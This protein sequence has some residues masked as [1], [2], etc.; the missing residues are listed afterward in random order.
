MTP[1]PA[2]PPLRVAKPV[3]LYS[4]LA[5]E[6]P[7]EELEDEELL[8]EELLE[9]EL[10]D[11]PLEEELDELDDEELL[12]DE[13]EELEE[14]LLEDELEPPLAGA[15]VAME[16][17]SWLELLAVQLFVTVPVLAD[18]LLEPAPPLPETALLQRTVWP[19]PAVKV[20]LEAPLV[21]ASTSQEFAV[22]TVTLAEIAVPEVAVAVLMPAVAGAPCT[23]PVSETEPAATSLTAPP[24]VT[25]T[26]CDPAAGL[27]R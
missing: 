24:K 3:S 23:T 9:D 20:A 15:K 12:E 16:S 25:A 19:V 14:E 2:V 13:L 10:E 8:E 4:E 11:D 6:L 26:E 7:D 21:T 27:S 17:A 1:P 18:D 5:P 22:A